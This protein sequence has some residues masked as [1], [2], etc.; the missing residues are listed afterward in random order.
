MATKDYTVSEIQTLVLDQSNNIKGI[1][2]TAQFQPEQSVEAYDE[3]CRECGFEN[4][5]TTDADKLQK[6]HWLIQRMRHWYLWQ[7]WQQYILR[8][9]GGDME[10]QQIVK[11]LE[12]IVNKM[13]KDFEAGKTAGTTAHLF[14]D[15]GTVFG[16]A[17]VIGPGFID[18]RLNE[19]TQEE[20]DLRTG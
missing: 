15:A 16:E 17:M 6:Y 10:A 2:S 4:P 5:E 14:N 8:F 20:L 13:D 18:D 19:D 12:V 1:D 11:N 7:L 9:K 3:A